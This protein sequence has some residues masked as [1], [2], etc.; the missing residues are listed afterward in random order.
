[1][2]L[3]VWFYS[4]KALISKGR[5]KCYCK[6]DKN[7]EIRDIDLGNKEDQTEFET[8][9]LDELCCLGSDDDDNNHSDSGM[10]TLEYMARYSLYKEY[11]NLI[12]WR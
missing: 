4:G 11:A 6:N 3:H 1:M 2:D 10:T 12:D 9:P 5:Q 8:L 7:T